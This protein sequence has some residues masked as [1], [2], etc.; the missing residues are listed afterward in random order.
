MHKAVLAATTPPFPP[1][2]RRVYE[3]KNTHVSG[4]YSY[5][6]NY[7]HIYPQISSMAALQTALIRNTLL[8]VL[9]LDVGRVF[10]DAP[11]G[12]WG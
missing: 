11:A 2:S 10:G 1:S 5:L 8:V 7:K 4:I 12:V 3:S 9:F 6:L